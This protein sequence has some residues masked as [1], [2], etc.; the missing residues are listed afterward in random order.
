MGLN[1]KNAAVERLAREVAAMA[2]ET[3]T[4][5]IRRAL[6]ERR[7]RLQAHSGRAGGRAGLREYM[8]RNVWPMIPPTELGRSLSR[9]EEDQIL[10]Y[11][12][13]GV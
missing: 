10:G 1:I 9:E 7:A 11:G 13:E 5:A 12:S 6:L 2:H 8:E 4:E 3:K